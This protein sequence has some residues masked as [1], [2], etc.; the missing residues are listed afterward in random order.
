M[1]KRY[2]RYFI[3][4]SAL[5]LSLSLQACAPAFPE[6][7]RHNGKVQSLPKDFPDYTKKQA[8][9]KKDEAE[10]LASTYWKKFFRDKYL[11][12]LIET[13][14]AQNQELR[15]LEQEINIAQNEIMA[16]R[17]EYLPKVGVGAG[18][19]LEKV[20]E[21]TSQGVS[22]ANN[23]YEEG[24]HVPEVLHNRH[25]GL[26]ASWEVDIWNRLRNRAK[27]AY[28]E[29]LATQEGKKFMVTRLVAE[30]ATTYYELLALDQQ[31]HII[32]EY[33]ANLQQAQEMVQLQFEAAK[34]T[35]L[36]VTRF[37]AEVLKNQSR[38][39]EL[40]QQIIITENRLNSLLGRF[41]QRITRSSK[42]LT[43]QPIPNVTT[44]LPSLLLDNRP[45]IKRASLALKAAKLNV[46]AAKA[47][48]YPSISLDAGVGYEAF[49][50]AHF[51][52]T[53]TS[54]FYTLAA[55]LSAPLLNRMAIKA[56]YFSAN[57]RQIQAIYDYELALVK[58]YAEVANQ[59]A[60][61][62]NLKKIYQLRT[63][64]VE[65]LSQS[66]DISMTL[67]KAARVDY[68]ESLLTQRDYLEAQLELVEVRK[69]QYAANVNLYRA[70]GGG[71]QTK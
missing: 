52:S 69:D 15:I 40:E 47:R 51:F 6:G 16:R 56:D 68:I 43:T 59:L 21:L 34:S 67:F 55:N 14:L 9:E 12:D 29:Y 60:S 32:K 42:P 24:K 58:G 8:Q 4:T 25:I 48:F 64:Q 11:N 20:G 50:S 53:P 22:D 39:Y 49:N 61:M 41:P 70:L 62:D 17:G 44:G 45:D 28:Y 10:M 38:Q 19:E 7:Q 27:A 37:Q 2:F 36:G 1:P 13:A 57:N 30:I 26:F 54:L 46:K 23:E 65:A 66:F 18:Y 5:C 31:L 33:I 3:L 35:S 63:K 71:W